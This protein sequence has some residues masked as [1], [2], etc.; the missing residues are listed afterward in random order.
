MQAKRDVHYYY[1]LR[2]IFKKNYIL[3]GLFLD[4]WRD[5][6]FELINDSTLRWFKKSTDNEPE[7]VI[8]INE[9]KDY[10]AVGQITRQIPSRPKININ[11]DLFYIQ[12]KHL[13]CIPK[14]KNLNAKEMLW[15][16][17]KEIDE[18]KLKC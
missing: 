12:E 10:F 4:Q 7:G 5:G 3:S 17:F 9:V 11:V 16:A 13:I 1:G 15:V 6:F 14:D 18:M 8:R 2:C